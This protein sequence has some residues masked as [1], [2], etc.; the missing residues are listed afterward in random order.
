MTHVD[1]GVMVCKRDLLDYIPER[2]VCSLEETVYSELIRR[3][4]L[5]AFVIDQR[6]YDMGSFSELELL[7]EVLK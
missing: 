4:E 2:Q 6:F 7:K 1:A 3:E 5:M